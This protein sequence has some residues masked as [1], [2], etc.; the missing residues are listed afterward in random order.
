MGVARAGNGAAFTGENV[1]IDLK[2]R[3]VFD[4][5]K[6]QHRR[7][8]QEHRTHRTLV[9]L[10][11]ATIVSLIATNSVQAQWLS[12]PAPPLPMHIFREAYTGSVT[13]RM[14]MN[15]D[16]TVRDVRLVGSSGHGDLDDLAV[17]TVRRWRLDP[18][19]IRPSDVTEG[20]GQIIGFRQDGT[21]PKQ[22]PPDAKAYWA[23]VR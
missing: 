16:G 17:A 15:Y 9:W 8:S 22:L 20:R 11:V 5:Q 23:L 2:N 10:L 7:M 14:L 18:K 13:L 19:E 6:R 1:P 3:L 12:R 21:A 4:C